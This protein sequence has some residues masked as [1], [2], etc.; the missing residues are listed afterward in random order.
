MIA[1]Q[2]A[3]IYEVKKYFGV[4]VHLFLKILNMFIPGV[5]GSVAAPRG[6]GMEG[7]YPPQESTPL[8]VAPV[9]LNKNN[10]IWRKIKKNN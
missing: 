8:A 10:G 3:C 2:G 5:K 6:R 7:T 4:S 9:S 1:W